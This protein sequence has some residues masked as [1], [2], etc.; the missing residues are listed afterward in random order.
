MPE[1]DTALS[2]INPDSFS[3]GIAISADF[4]PP[5]FGI[6]QSG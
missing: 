3:S 4:N 5:L 6:R 1:I 2:K